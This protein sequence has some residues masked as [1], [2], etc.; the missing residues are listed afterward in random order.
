MFTVKRVIFIGMIALLIVSLLCSSVSAWSGVGTSSRPWVI[1]SQADLQRLAG[2]SYI[3]YA[4]TSKYFE[5]SQNITVSDTF[6]SIG[7]NQYKFNG[8]FNGKGY[9]ISGLRQP[10]M[11]ESSGTIQNLNFE[12][13]II[14]TAGS[15]GTL[16]SVVHGGLIDNVNLN[17]CF[18]KSDNTGGIVG[19]VSGE[20]AVIQNCNVK[21]C[22]IVGNS[23]S[24][25]ITSISKSST[26]IN[27]VKVSK[28]QIIS[29]SGKAFGVSG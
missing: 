14:Q 22:T 9:T 10:F 28:S 2:G 3:S 24:A 5:L 8:K 23:L 7:N 4:G 1:S 15:G 20:N 17:N 13:C 29:L 21:S 18:I 27:N 6:K 25:G 16:V 12:N 26:S 11:A 19:E